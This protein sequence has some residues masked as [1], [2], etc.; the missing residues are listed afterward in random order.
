MTWSDDEEEFGCYNVYLC[1][2]CDDS[3]P[4]K[5]ITN[6]G[7]RQRWKKF[8]TKLVKTAVKR[9]EYQPKYGMT[10]IKIK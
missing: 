3:K 1:N 4:R 6:H 10:K 5:D 8:I 2:R 7:M 9:G